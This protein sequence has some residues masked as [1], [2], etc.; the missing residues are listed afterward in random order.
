[1]ENH[2]QIQLDRRV[3]LIL[4]DWLSDRPDEEDVALHLA[5]RK[6]EGAL[7]PTLDELFDPDYQQ[8]LSNAKTELSDEA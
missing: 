8:I 1:M 5:L 4:F 2:V 6:L 3:A 7:G